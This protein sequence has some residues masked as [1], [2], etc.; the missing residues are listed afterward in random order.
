MMAAATNEPGLG[1]PHCGIFAKTGCAA[2]GIWNHPR[3]RRVRRLIDVDEKA[4]I[5][6]G[7]AGAGD[8]VAL[9]ND[10]GCERL[11]GDLIHD[12]V[13][14]VRRAG[15]CYGRSRNDFSFRLGGAA[16]TLC[17][18]GCRRFCFFK[19]GLALRRHR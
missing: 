19:P 10:H 5:E 16:A 12:Q 18:F 1:V 3:L 15:F 6:A 13:M 4:V 7:E 2:A 17:G 8:A 14:T 9:E 11:I